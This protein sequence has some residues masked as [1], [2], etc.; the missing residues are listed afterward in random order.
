MVLPIHDRR[1]PLYVTIH[2]AASK[3]QLTRLRRAYD[4]ATNNPSFGPDVSD[5]YS[6]V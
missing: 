5:G 2:R 3:E 6:F 4:D 1:S